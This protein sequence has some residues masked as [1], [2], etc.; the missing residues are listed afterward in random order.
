MRVV[1]AFVLMLFSLVSLADEHA[2]LY[3][4]AG[5]P[6]QREHFSDALVVAQQ[7]YSNTLPPAVYQAL[8]DNSNRRFAAQALEQRSQA[9]LRAQLSNP[10]PALQ[11]FESPLGRKVIAAEVLATRRDQ[12]AKNAKGLPRSDASATRRLLIRHLAQA[13]PASDAAAEVSLALAG[14]AADSLSQMLPGLLGGGQAQALLDN[15]REQFKQQINTDLDNTLLYV[16]RD[17]S[18][19]ELEEFVSFAQSSDG[20]AYYRAALGALRAGLG[21]QQGAGQGI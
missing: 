7:R 8:V 19:P 1:F 12:L 5:W 10:Q 13:V 6:Q 14:V 9:A 18:D 4:A 20:Q 17:L 15:Q 3:Q 21:A 11:F 16:Y 2:R